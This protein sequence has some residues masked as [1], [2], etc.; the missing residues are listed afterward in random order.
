VRRNV[1]PAGH[2]LPAEGYQGEI[3]DWPLMEGSALELHRWEALWRSPIAV[4]WATAGLGDALQVA[5]LVRL[6]VTMED[7][8]NSV[9]TAQTLSALLML[10]KNL[11]IG[12]EARKRL[13]YT[14]ATPE[15]EQ[16][17]KISQ[18]RRLKAVDPDAS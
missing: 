4:E 5:R 6:S 14:I 3:P 12:V 18:I 17:A 7:S 13:G 2:E 11:G 16:A 10:E 8:R 1:K 9:A 15:P